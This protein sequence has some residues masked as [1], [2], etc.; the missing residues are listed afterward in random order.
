MTSEEFSRFGLFTAVIFIAVPLFSLNVHMSGGRLFFDQSDRHQQASLFVSLLVSGIAF[1]GGGVLLGIGV[2]QS[3]GISDPLTLGD[4]VLTV[5]VGLSVVSSVMVQ[6]FGLLF[7]LVDRPSMFA[8]VSAQLGFGLLGIYAAIEGQF[9]DKLLAA[10][11]AYLANNL[12]VAVVAGILAR[13]HLLP[14]RFSRAMIG[15]AISYGSGTM[16][17]TVVSWV[18]AQSGRWIGTLVMPV[19]AL[20]GYTLMTYAAMAANLAATVLFETM[21][22]DIM[23]S[24]VKGDFRRSRRIID[25][26]AVVLI[27]IVVLIYGVVIVLQTWQDKFLPPSYHIDRGLVYAALA[28]SVFQVIF[29]RSFWLATSYKRTKTLASVMVVAAAATVVMSW[30]LVREYGDLGLMV[31]AAVGAFILALVGNILMT[32]IL[33]TRHASELG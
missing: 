7:R 33:R 1:V 13:E 19:A 15:P 29:M 26:T 9:A 17:H 2:L 3:L 18:N 31:G 5:L 23:N 8:L 28:F 16:V 27:G 22:I 6:F 11:V 21:R 30:L 12:L 20:A 4:P 25:R 14:G 24:H 32:H 10:V